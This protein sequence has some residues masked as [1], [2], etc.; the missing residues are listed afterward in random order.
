MVGFYIISFIASVSAFGMFCLIMD[1]MYPQEEEIYIA[2]KRAITFKQNY[3]TDDDSYEDS[4]LNDN[5]QIVDEQE[6]S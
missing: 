2:P 6:E 1:I 5:Y 4:Y 3:I